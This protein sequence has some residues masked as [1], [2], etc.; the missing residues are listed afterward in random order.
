M[1]DPVT[2]SKTETKLYIEVPRTKSKFKKVFTSK[3]FEAKDTPI[4]WSH[5]P[6][7]HGDCSICHEKDDPKDPGKLKGDSNQQCLGCH[8]PMRHIMETRRVVHEPAAKDCTSCH[9]P[10]NANHR[11]LLHAPPKKLCAS[12]HLDVAKRQEKA[13]FKHAPVARGNTCSNCHDSHASSVQYLLKKLPA[14]LCLECHGRDGLNDNQGRELPNLARLLKENPQHHAPIPKKDCSACHSVH[15]SKY[16]RLLKKNYPS[17]FYA[18]YNKENYALCT[19]CH[20][21]QSITTAETDALTGFRDGKRNLHAVHVKQ[22]DRGRTCRAC[23][24]VHATRQVHLIRKDVPYGPSGWVLDINFVR[25]KTGGRC[26]KTCHD[27]REYN[28]Q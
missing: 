20:N 10:H 9:N 4:R 28:N 6:F 17:D 16:F 11:L 27:T 8:D 14:D 23:H 2:K 22:P 25:T 7:A 12:C 21:E 26:T 24:G 3:P 15:G 13:T 1:S 19:E 5:A 18:P